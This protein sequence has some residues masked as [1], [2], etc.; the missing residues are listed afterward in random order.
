MKC[1]NRLPLVRLYRLLPVAV[2]LATSLKGQQTPTVDLPRDEDIR[3]ATPEHRRSIKMVF[4]LPFSLT[5][6]PVEGGFE[7]FC[8]PLP[9]F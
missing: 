6:N 9:A 4:H 8:L 3:L 2:L 1:K 5:I 7:G